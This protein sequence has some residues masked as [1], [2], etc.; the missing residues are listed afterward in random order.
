M[1]SH[2]ETP[3][4]ETVVPARVEPRE[5]GFVNALLEG[6]DGIATMRTLDPTRGLVVFWVPEGQRADFDA[7]IAGFQRE[8]AIALIDC[9]DP[10]LHGLM[11]EEWR[12][13]E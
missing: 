5:I 2:P 13:D 6:H 1:A 10:I 12:R 8:I 11:L 3:P 7:M 4:P 9:E